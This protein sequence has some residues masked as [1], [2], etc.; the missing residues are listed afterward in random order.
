MIRKAIEKLLSTAAILGMLA[1]VPGCA[2]YHP[3][4]LS[5][6]QSAASFSHRSLT[7]AG[8]R[9]FMQS[10]IGYP[11]TPW[12]P[13]TW[14]LDRLTLAALHYH[15]QLSLARSQWA[16]ARAK[17]VTAGAYPNP[18]LKLMPF[19]QYMSNA[20]AGVSPW[21]IGLSVDIP[22][23]TA[24][25]RSYRVAEA[26][27]RARAARFDVEQV[28]W[29]I[30]VNLR[31]SLIELYAARRKA[32]L[33]NTRS[34]DAAALLAALR[35]RLA[36]GQ[37]SRFQVVQAR[38]QWTNAQ[39]SRADAKTAEIQARTALAGALGVPP[40]ALRGVQID[41]HTLQVLP[42]P[43][44]IPRIRFETYALTRRPDIR[45]ALMRY[46]ASE[47]AL[48][49]E[50]ARQ[51]PNLQVGPG[52]QW[53]QGD[54]RWAIGLSLRLP[55]FNQ[56][57]G[58]I[59]EA[60]AQRERAAARFRVLQ[61]QIRTQLDSALVGYRASYH[62]LELAQHLL[63]A[64]R[65]RL[66]SAR[67]T[68]RAGETSRVDLLRIRLEAQSDQLAVLKAHIRSE[69]ALAMLEDALEHPLHQ[70]TPASRAIQRVASPLHTPSNAQPAKTSSS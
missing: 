52:Y 23:L 27:A 47:Q 22:I 66:A 3:R 46:A 21:T 59:A 63:S 37:I 15:P 34:Q 53:D 39:L 50:I 36:A 32:E 69:R 26:L 40:S 18:T 14:T 68:C 29:R 5:A 35:Q 56:N 43:K 60:R 42:A 19:P 17:A 30:R 67:A 13:K 2:S 7:N 45:A 57:Q 49:L 4:P 12:P 61:A 11:I 6:K 55:I 8:L 62:E 48:Q 28:A 70:P 44:T 1:V 31:K 41:F 25:K 24:G 10:R 65:V 64:V 16:I 54:R 20:A 9:A 58:P 33:L 38:L 51:Y